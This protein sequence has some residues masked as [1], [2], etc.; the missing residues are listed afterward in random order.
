TMFTG[1]HPP[2]SLADAMHAAWIAFART[3]EP[4]TERLPAWPAYGRAERVTMHLGV[5][6]HVE[7]DPSAAEREAWTNIL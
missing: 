7:S 3:A 4:V 2:Q 1:P 6:C 5:P